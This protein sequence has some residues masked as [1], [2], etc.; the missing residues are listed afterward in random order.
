[1]AGPARLQYQHSGIVGLFGIHRDFRSS[2]APRGRQYGVDVNT[3][4]KVDS[5][6]D[7]GRE[8]SPLDALSS[9]QRLQC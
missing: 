9:V 5:G 6:S 2:L 7:G 3:L 4:T 1:M 8:R